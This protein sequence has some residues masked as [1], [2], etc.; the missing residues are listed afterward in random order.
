VV[1]T[2]ACSPGSVFLSS[3]ERGMRGEGVERGFL[4]SLGELP[5]MRSGTGV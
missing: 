4:S 2:Q 5:L 1:E 3:T